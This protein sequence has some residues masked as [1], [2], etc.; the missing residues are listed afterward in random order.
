MGKLIL[1]IDD[2]KTIRMIVTKALKAAG[3]DTIE[4]GNGREGIEAVN[5]QLQLAIDVARL[6]TWDWDLQTGKITWSD[7]FFTLLGYTPG[8]IEPS[9]QTWFKHLEPQLSSEEEAI[10]SPDEVRKE[11]HQIFKCVRKDGT[12]IWCEARAR[13]ELDGDGSGRR[14]LGVVMDINEHKLAEERQRL[15]VQELHHRVKNNLQVISSMLGLQS[16]SIADEPGERRRG[17][18]A[19]SCSC[20]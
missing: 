17:G 13:L 7:Q 6:G 8:E 16:R 14:M 10:Q 5:A 19:A 1:V 11:N 9:T 12:S 18:A 20:S 2:S 3:F 4:A 15:M